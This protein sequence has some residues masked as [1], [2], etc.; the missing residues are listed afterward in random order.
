MVKEKVTYVCMGIFAIAVFA[1]S[2]ETVSRYIKETYEK[3]YFSGML[4]VVLISGGYVCGSILFSYLIIKIP[5]RKKFLVTVLGAVFLIRVSWIFL[6]RTTPSSDFRVLHEATLNILQGDLTKIY[7]SK[8]LSA[9]P[10]QIGFVVYQAIV[11]KL[12]GS[13]GIM[14]LKLMNVIFS[15]LTG[16]L[17]YLTAK[18]MSNKK[19]ARVSILIWCFYPNSIYVCSVLTN[20]IL[21]TFL[22]VIAIYVFIKYKSI[23]SSVL[24]GGVIALGNIIRPEGIVVLTAISIYVIFCQKINGKLIDKKILIKKFFR[25]GAMLGVYF[26]VMNIASGLITFGGISKYPL[27]NRRPY[28]KFVLGFNYETKGGYSSKD[29]SAHPNLSIGKD[30]DKEEK[31]IMINRTHDKIKL[32][33][34]FFY[35]FRDF[36]GN[37]DNTIGFVKSGIKITQFKS[38]VITLTEKLYYTGTMLFLMVYFIYNIKTRRNFIINPIIILI[39]VFMSVYLLIEIQTRYR[40]F[41]IP[42]LCIYSAY[43]MYLLDGVKKQFSTLV[44]KSEH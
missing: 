21:A 29:A 37:I 32:I 39:L 24:I 13:S 18:E 28:W 6:F 43:G 35:K 15:T 1:F 10:Y 27:S 42:F 9:Y 19:V 30:L 34:L 20:Q 2:C 38:S 36:W 22:F 33:K 41:I 5:S 16:I 17:I 44:S 11:M 25:I 8:Y 23:M 3:Q 4:K 26:I 31:N 14:I 40:Y 12:S 7:D